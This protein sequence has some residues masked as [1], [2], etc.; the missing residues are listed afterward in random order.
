MFNG[1]WDLVTQRL[2]GQHGQIGWLADSTEKTRGAIKLVANWRT[3][4]QTKA[5][6]HGEVANRIYMNSQVESK[7]FIHVRLIFFLDND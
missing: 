2:G 1:T 6:Q 5:T 4:T 3:S 7:C